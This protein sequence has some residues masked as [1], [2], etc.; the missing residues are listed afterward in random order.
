MAYRPGA[1]DLA[2][3]RCGYSP[4]HETVRS[5]RL[6][7]RDG[8]SAFPEQRGRAAAWARDHAGLDTELLDVQQPEPPLRVQRLR[9]VTARGRRG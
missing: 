5:L 4:L 6:R 7:A 3:T 9:A 8:G 1:K 2:A